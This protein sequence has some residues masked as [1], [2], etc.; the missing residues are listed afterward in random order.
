MDASPPH[1]SKIVGSQGPLGFRLNRIN[2]KSSLLELHGYRHH[3]FWPDEGIAERTILLPDS[4]CDVDLW[5]DPR[6]LLRI[7]GYC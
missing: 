1:L 4:L 6:E 5:L 2:Q 3:G 7:G